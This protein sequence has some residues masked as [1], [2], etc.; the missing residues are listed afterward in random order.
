MQLCV[1]ED[2]RRVCV[3]DNRWMARRAANLQ[4]FMSG[5]AS[6]RQR[7]PMPQTTMWAEMDGLH[8]GWWHGGGYVGGGMGMGGFQGGRGLDP[9]AG[10]VETSSVVA[11]LALWQKCSQELTSCPPNYAE[12]LWVCL[13]LRLCGC[14]QYLCVA[15]IMRNSSGIWCA[16]KFVT[17]LQ[18]GGKQTK[19]NWSEVSRCKQM[20]FGW[21][22]AWCGRPSEP[23]TNDAHQ[24]G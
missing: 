16:F 22:G 15:W 12:C 10:G 19:P 14:Q 21:A 7:Q 13:L 4:I 1:C 11:V 17:G 2:F 18:V 20:V 24:I 3:L 8:R 5:P 6:G 9:L 23:T